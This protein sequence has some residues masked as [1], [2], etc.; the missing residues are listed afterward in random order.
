MRFWVPSINSFIFPF[1]LASITLRDVFLLT[2]LPMIGPD[3]LCLIDIEDTNLIKYS[4]ASTDFSSY[5]SLIQHRVKNT[6]EPLEKEHV[7]F[8]WVLIC[9]FFICPS[10]KKSTVEY[11]H[12][13]RAVAS[14]KFF[15]LGTILLSLT[16]R[17]LNYYHS[18]CPFLKFG[19]SLWLIQLR[20]FAYFPEIHRS[21]LQD[22]HLPIGIQLFSCTSSLGLDD[23]LAFF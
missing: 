2:G 8:L 4:A 18:C 20:L 7:E 9:K 22:S 6:S 19:G 11:L 12:L 23:A 13:A 17:S 21:P 1:G 10:S 16:Y 5:H 14:R 15:A 3:A